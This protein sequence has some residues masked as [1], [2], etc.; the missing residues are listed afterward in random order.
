MVYRCG[1]AP[2][3]L[4][5]AIAEIVLYLHIITNAF[6]PMSRITTRRELKE[7]LRADWESYGFK[8]PL[9]ARFTFSENGTMFAYVRNLRYLEYYTNKRQRPW[10]GLL[11]AWHLL[12]WRRMNLRHQL[13]IKPNCCGK[14][15]HLVHHGYRRIDSVQ[16]IGDNCTILPMTLIGKKNPDADISGATIGNNCYIG[17]GALIMNPVTIGDNVTIGAGSVVT[18]DIPDNCTVAGNP[19]RIIRREAPGQPK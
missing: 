6:C 17:A 16:S 13:Y 8:Y 19:A 4:Y 18:K 10:D 3:P 12:R 14:G 9:L 2:A 1:I 11:R 7:W 15:L 5:W